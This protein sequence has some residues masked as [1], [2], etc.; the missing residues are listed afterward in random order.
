MR[1][2]IARELRQLT[3]QMFTDKPMVEYEYREIMH[4]GRSMGMGTTRYLKVDCLK[5]LTEGA[6]ANWKNYL[7]PKG[8]E[9]APPVQRG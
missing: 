9:Q 1:G 8:G 4:G 2:K 6:K 7:P 5:A 3:R